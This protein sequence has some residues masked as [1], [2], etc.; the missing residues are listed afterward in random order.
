MYVPGGSGSG[1]EKT[2]KSWELGELG[3]KETRWAEAAASQIL[4]KAVKAQKLFST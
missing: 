2:V 4:V 1:E 3:E